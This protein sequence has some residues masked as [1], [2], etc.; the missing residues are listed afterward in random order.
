M[1]PFPLFSAL[2]AAEHGHLVYS[3]GP[4]I[5]TEEIHFVRISSGSTGG[6]QKKWVIRGVSGDVC[7]VR[8]IH[9]QSDLLAVLQVF[10]QRTLVSPHLYQMDIM[11]NQGIGP[12]EFGCCR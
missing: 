9:P 3:M 4:Q 2:F 12:S 11:F 5:E 7:I 8:A 6:S 10:D 1:C